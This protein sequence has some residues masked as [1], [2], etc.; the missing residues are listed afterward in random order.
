MLH[1]TP[2][3]RSV[4]RAK[5]T[6]RRWAPVASKSRVKKLQLQV[7]QKQSGQNV[8]KRDLMRFSAVVAKECGGYRSSM[9]KCPRQKCS[10]GKKSRGISQHKTDDCTRKKCRCPCLLNETSAGRVK[11]CHKT[12]YISICEQTSVFSPTSK[13]TRNCSERPPLELSSTD[14][15]N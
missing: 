15:I 11:T 2:E 13:K 4:K 5:K 12:R 6:T 14:T 8:H 1:R 7:V 3:S 9:W 10:N